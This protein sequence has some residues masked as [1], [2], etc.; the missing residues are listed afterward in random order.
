LLQTASFG[1]HRV[2]DTRHGTQHIVRDDAILLEQPNA[3]VYLNE[4]GSI[5]VIVPARDSDSR[6]LLSLPVIIQEDVEDRLIRAIGYVDRVLDHVDPTQRL[7]RVALA[8]SVQG[9]GQFG[10]R[11]RAEHAQSPNSGQLN[12]WAQGGAVGLSPPDRARGALRRNA[13][14]LAEDLTI[15]LRR[16]SQG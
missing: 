2:L 13:N 8:A 4:E 14:E 10:W 15:R 12:P 1:Q 6:G 3:S 7:T 16:K 11:T 5:R 9:G